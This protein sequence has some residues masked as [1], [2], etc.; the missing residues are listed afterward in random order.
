MFSLFQLFELFNKP[1]CTHE[2]IT[3]DMLAGYCPDCGEYVENQWFLTR[4]TCCGIKQKTIF[5][6]GKISSENKF[7]KNCGSNYFGI[8]K[9]N[10]IT[11]IDIHYA[12]ILKQ[13][14]DNRKKSVIQTWVENEP[15]APK[16]LTGCCY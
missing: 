12:A 5:L 8:E 13:V 16:L 1:S 15:F 11:F 3:P 14:I 10:K 2:K 4:C 9:L 7:C 6:R